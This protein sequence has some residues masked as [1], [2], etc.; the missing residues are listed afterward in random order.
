LEARLTS[1]LKQ[2]EAQ[3]SGRDTRP[4]KGARQREPDEVGRY[5]R[6]EQ[7]EPGEGRRK[8]EE[9]RQSRRERTYLVKED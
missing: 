1:L 9:Y 8:V 5:P 4:T 3:P 2:S 7:I 6:K